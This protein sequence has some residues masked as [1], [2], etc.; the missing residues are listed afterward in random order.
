MNF[1]MTPEMERSMQFNER[2]LR[3]SVLQCYII[4]LCMTARGQGHFFIDVH[5]LFIAD[6][7]NSL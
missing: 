5:T 3:N 4:C 1:F 7:C 6:T 2:L